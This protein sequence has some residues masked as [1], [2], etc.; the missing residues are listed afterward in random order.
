[1]DR[2]LIADDEDEIRYV[3]TKTLEGHFACETVSDGQAAIEMIEANPPDAV[4]TDLK[5]PQVSGID[6]L[7]A[8]RIKDPLIPVIVITGYG[9]LDT[10]IEALRLGAYDYIQKPFEDL[11]IIRNTLEHALESRNLRRENLLLLEDLRHSNNFKSQLLRTVAHD[12]KNML[13][14]VIG[15][16]DLAQ[17]GGTLQEVREQL[18]DIRLVAQNMQLL[19]DDL[20]TYGQLDSKALRL[21]PQHVRVSDCV[22]KASRLLLIDPRRHSLDLPQDGPSVY[23]DAHRTTQILNNLMGNAVKYSPMGGV[24]RVSVQEIGEDVRIS[25]SDSGIGIP[26]EDLGRLFTAFF[27]VE[28]DARSDIPGTGLGLTIV[29]NLVESHGG[30][31]TVESTEGVGTTFSFTLPSTR[32]RYELLVGAQSGREHVVS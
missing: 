27:R 14:G 19:A 8:A 29:K 5:M 21:Y 32:E 17:M 25:V 12:F 26:A 24:V 11:R 7:A 31:V 13:Q 1:M 4:I 20:T 10:A 16:S 28:R 3:I 2:I 18:S 23:A 22:L 15:F 9:T 6:V 30:R